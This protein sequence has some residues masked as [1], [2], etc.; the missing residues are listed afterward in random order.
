VTIAEDPTTTT[1]KVEQEIM[2]P[3]GV[4]ADIAFHATFLDIDCVQARLA[5]EQRI[6][7]WTKP[8]HDTTLT[9]NDLLD[10]EPM[11]GTDYARAVA[12]LTTRITPI[13]RR[14]VDGLGDLISLAMVGAGITD[15]PTDQYETFMHNVFAE[16]GIE[17]RFN[18][19][20]NWTGPEPESMTKYLESKGF[21]P[22]SA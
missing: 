20:A 10:L 4:V 1:Y 13:I 22:P 2:T 9:F 3:E 7:L 5:I 8:P 18:T 11:I 17:D 21:V 12:D 14:R 16:A 19:E 6:G 15:M